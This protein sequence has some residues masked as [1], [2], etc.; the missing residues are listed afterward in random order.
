M[1]SCFTANVVQREFYARPNRLQKP[2]WPPPEFDTKRPASAKEPINNENNLSGANEDAANHKLTNEQSQQEQKA[3]TTDILPLQPKSMNTLPPH[4]L[5][6]HLAREQF[7]NGTRDI[8]VVPQQH[9]QQEEQSESTQSD[10]LST[11][12]KPMEME[13][14]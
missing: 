6:N 7:Y 2:V 14:K 1:F 11:V 3:L 4:R 8:V 13:E 12:Q 10:E 5:A 9:T